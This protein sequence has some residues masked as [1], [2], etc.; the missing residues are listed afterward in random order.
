MNRR[1]FLMGVAGLAGCTPSRPRLNIYNW[2][3]YVAPDTISSFEAQFGVS[4]RYATYES[5]EE[6]LAKV[7][8]GNSGWDVV[9]PTHN[10]I[11]PMRQYGLL[12]PLDHTLLTNLSNLEPRFQVPPWDPHL[13]YGVPYMW[14]AT[15]IAYNCSVAP[16]PTAWADLWSPRLKGRITMLDDPEELP[17]AVPRHYVTIG[18]TSGDSNQTRRR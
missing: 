2:S 13:E 1:A 18:A 10:R 8:G 9:F 3:N 5:N 15:G 14:G 12:A 16:P 7:L 6:M 11:P 4:V 17:A